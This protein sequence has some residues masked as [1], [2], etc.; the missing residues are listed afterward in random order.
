MP[1]II[2]RNCPLADHQHAQNM[3]QYAH[4]FHHDNTI[5]VARALW[6]LPKKHREAVL[7]HEIGHL[8]VGPEGS[9]ED[10]NQAVED[11]T[12]VHI[13]YVDSPYG[14]RLEIKK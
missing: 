14:V 4:T 11:A 9:E 12:G 6:K 2:L 10:A 1:E 5:C 8:L 13:Y 7:L 3:R